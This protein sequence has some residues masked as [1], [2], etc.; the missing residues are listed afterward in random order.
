M[1]LHP[2]VPD[3]ASVLGRVVLEHQA[4]HVDD[5]LA[6]PNYQLKEQRSIGGY[7]TVLGVP[8]MRED[9]SIGVI[10]LSRSVVKPFTDKQI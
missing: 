10:I 6:D 7:R 9:S 1:R 3:R 5:V 8:L 4:V 2:L